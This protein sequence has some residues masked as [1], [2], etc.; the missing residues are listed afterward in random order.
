MLIFNS[1]SM[2]AV[3]A[4]ARR[5]AR[6]SGTVLITGES[7]TGKELLAQYLHEQ[8][9]RFGRPCVRVNCAAF[10]EGLAESELFGHEQGA[11]TGAA[12]RHDGFLHAAADGTLFL[13]EIGELPLPTQAKLLRVLEEGEYLRV[14][15]TEVQRVNARIIAATNRDLLKEVAEKRF[16]D[17]LY[18]RLDVLTL[19]LSPLRERP[20]D[21]PALVEHF[22]TQ[23]GGENETPV[24]EVSDEVME[25]L[26]SFHWPG[27]VR[28]L[29]NTIHRACVEAESNTIHQISLG[30][31]VAT[32]SD[33]TLPPQFLTLPLDEI[34]R[35]IILSRLRRFDGNKTEAAAE[36]GV[37]PRTLRNKIAR[38][39]DLKKA[40]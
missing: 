32:T 40:G 34:E 21:I 31:T 19:R 12:R 17:D 26:M 18:H 25:Q 24:T 38:W 9:P 4:K 11:F 8:S 3:L 39:H 28:Q 37:T 30:R 13:D 35:M 14:G 10:H 7:G 16:R 29:R 23:F 5:F 15:S 2:H 22:I 6:S 20:E 33:G 36:L 1:S 27:N